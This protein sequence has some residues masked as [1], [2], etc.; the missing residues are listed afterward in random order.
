MSY[1][2]NDDVLRFY[3]PVQDVQGVEVTDRLA[4]LSQLRHCLLLRHFLTAFD[5][6]VE[7]AVLHILHEDVEV[8]G[9][10]EAAVELDHVG[11]R[12]EETDLN[13]LDELLQHQPH[14]LL[15][16]LLDST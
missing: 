11:V 8:E 14:V 6:P 13:L 15:F 10:L 4:D 16:H 1:I 3:V 2:R 9:V 12:Q 5:E 7:G